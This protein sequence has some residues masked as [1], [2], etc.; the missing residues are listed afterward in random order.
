MN[1]AT[2][3][4]PLSAHDA[5]EARP[6]LRHLGRVA[7]LQAPA[8]A[9]PVAQDPTPVRPARGM[10][11]RHWARWVAVSAAIVALAAAGGFAVGLVS[12]LIGA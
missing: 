5:T 11:M 8:A 4:F 1:T 2:A 3:T 7:P 6:L 10:R 12:A 9:V